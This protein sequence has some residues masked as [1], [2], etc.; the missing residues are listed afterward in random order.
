[1]PKEYSE[2]LGQLAGTIEDNSLIDRFIG[3]SLTDI[4]KRMLIAD[5][6]V[7]HPQTE[8]EV[9]DWTTALCVSMDGYIGEKKLEDGPLR[10]VIGDSLTIQYVNTTNDQ[11]ALEWLRELRKQIRH[12]TLRR[13]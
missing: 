1:M 12:N 5:M 9:D 2:W 4:Q 11:E 10:R 6:L 8:K 7:P 3:D 13:M